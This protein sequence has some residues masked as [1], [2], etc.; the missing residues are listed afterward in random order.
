MSS[1]KSHRREVFAGGFLFTDLQLNSPRGPDDVEI[2]GTRVGVVLPR[3]IQLPC[4]VLFEGVRNASAGAIARPNVQAPIV[5]NFVGHKPGELLFVDLKWMLDLNAIAI[6]PRV[7]LRIA[8]AP[9][10]II[11]I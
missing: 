8:P 1:T 5:E 6:T 10:E 9:L 2:A 11:S 7:H 4:E 3:V